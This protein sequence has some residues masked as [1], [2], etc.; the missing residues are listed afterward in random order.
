MVVFLCQVN[1]QERLMDLI[2]EL[3]QHIVLSSDGWFLI[4]VLFQRS[5]H[6]VHMPTKSLRVPLCERLLCE[7]D[8]F[9]S[10][11]LS[12]PHLIPDLDVCVQMAFYTP[13]YIVTRL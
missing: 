4:D 9:W 11:L 12:F 7:R 13:C 5:N 6:H 10:A 1:L 8:L 2:E 3:Y